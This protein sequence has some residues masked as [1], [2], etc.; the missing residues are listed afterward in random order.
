[1]TGDFAEPD[2]RAA[3]FAER[4]RRNQQKLVSQLKPHYDFI[5]CGPGSSGSVV[6]RRL[7]ENPRRQR[8]AAGRPVA[9][10]THRL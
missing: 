10:T 4:V 6:A 3:D 1:M 8:V 9:R 5:V 7:A 2:D